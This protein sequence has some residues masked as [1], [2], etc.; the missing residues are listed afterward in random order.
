MRA[1]RFPETITRR[2]EGPG[3]RNQFGEWTPGAMSEKKFQASVQPLGLEDRDLIEGA[4]LVHRLKVFIPEPGA[5]V[6]V[7]DDAKGDRVAYGGAEYI[8]QESESWP[9]H[10]KAT[11]VRSA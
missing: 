6:A 10:T 1:R 11:L 7:F 3:E 2:R 8:V 4:R 5:L 9:D